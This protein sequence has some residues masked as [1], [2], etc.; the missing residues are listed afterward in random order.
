MLEVFYKFHKDKLETDKCRQIVEMAVA[1]AFS[2]DTIKLNLKL[3]Q[4]Q[5]KGKE[6]VTAANVGD[7]IVK[8]AEAIFGVGVV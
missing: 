7:D 4:G 2:V 3:G 5:K 6:E 8:A 1:E